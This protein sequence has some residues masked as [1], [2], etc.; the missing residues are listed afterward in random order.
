MTFLGVMMIN[1]DMVDK[2]ELYLNDIS[3][4]QYGLLRDGYD[5]LDFN[6]ICELF[7]LIKLEE[8]LNKI[9]IT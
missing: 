3:N 4:L 5:N 9:S 2:A 1:L 7:L 6:L 8:I